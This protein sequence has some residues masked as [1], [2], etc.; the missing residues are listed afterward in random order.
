MTLHVR[1]FV[2]ANFLRHD[3]R[4]VATSWFGRSEIHLNLSHIVQAVMSTEYG[5]AADSIY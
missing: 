4:T 2:R 1:V 3:D 5:N